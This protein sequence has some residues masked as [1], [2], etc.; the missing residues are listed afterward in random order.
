MGI[1]NSREIQE[2]LRRELEA[3]RQ[4]LEEEFEALRKHEQQELN[5][6]SL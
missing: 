4:S 3:F 5:R 1:D 2:M 6:G